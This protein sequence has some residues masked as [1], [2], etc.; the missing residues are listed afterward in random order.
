[1]GNVASFRLASRNR[2]T[3]VTQDHS[4]EPPKKIAPQSPSRDN[5]GSGASPRAS[6]MRL[7]NQMTIQAT[8]KQNPALERINCPRPA[9]RLPPRHEPKPG[10]AA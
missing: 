9:A 4:Q 1:M 6:R 2:L 3:L 8:M 5:V 10:V 7:R